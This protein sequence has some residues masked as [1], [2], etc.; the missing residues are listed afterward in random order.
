MS[1]FGKLQASNVN[2]RLEPNTSEISDEESRKIVL[3]TNL[4]MQVCYRIIFCAKNGICDN[5]RKHVRIIQI[6]IIR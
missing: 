1:I 4:T 3:L 5:N 2:V 6:R